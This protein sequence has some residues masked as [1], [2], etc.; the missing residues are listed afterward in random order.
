MS[1]PLPDEPGGSPIDAGIG[2][3][4]TSTAS[5]LAAPLALAWP[6][7]TVAQDKARKVL[8]VAFSSAETTFDPARIIDLYSRT[9]TSHIFEALYG[10][11]ELHVR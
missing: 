4:L 1:P 2:V 6:L 11:D 7:A 5:L 3:V 10:W 9:V 8:R